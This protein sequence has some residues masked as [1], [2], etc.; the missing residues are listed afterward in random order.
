MAIKT[1]D[2]LYDYVRRQLGAPFVDVEVHEDH[3]ND[4][5]NDVVKEFSEFAY[6]GELEEVVILSVDGSGTYTLPTAIQAISKVA[7]GTSAGGLTNFGGNFGSGYVPDIW[8]EQYFSGSAGIGGIIDSIIGVS[9][10]QSMLDT[11]M[12][13]DIA[14]DFNPH[15]KTLR[16]FEPYVGSLLVM[17]SKEYVPDTIDYIYDATWV[18]K[19]CTAQARFVQSTV[20]GKYSQALVGGAMINYSDMRASAEQEIDRL[21]EELQMQYSGPAPMFVG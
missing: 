15:K 12:G 17:Y 10:T 6:E 8:S 18:K 5:V 14:Y 7:Q 2:E 9:T 16:I 21:K 19:M 13:D 1:R 11:F 20:T 4:I 3:L